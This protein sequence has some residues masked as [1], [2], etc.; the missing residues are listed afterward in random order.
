[1]F[2]TVNVKK[3]VVNKQRDG[4]ISVNVEHDGPWEIYTDSGFAKNISATI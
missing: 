2:C 1:M 3:I 4:Y